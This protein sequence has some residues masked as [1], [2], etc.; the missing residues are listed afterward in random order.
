MELFNW[1]DTVATLAYSFMAAISVYWTGIFIYSVIAAIRHGDSIYQDA[2]FGMT[3]F[4]ASISYSILSVSTGSFTNS[5]LSV[6]FSHIRTL[7]L[8]SALF[9]II[10]TVMHIYHSNQRR[11][12][13]IERGRDIVE[14]LGSQ[15]DKSGSIRYYKAQDSG[16]NLAQ[17]S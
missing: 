11:R 8:I 2:F 15:P 1:S 7:F 6:G 10:S 5:F 17:D 9:G 13:E 12:K 16:Q 14:L 4:M 3:A